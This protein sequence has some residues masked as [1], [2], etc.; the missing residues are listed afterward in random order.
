MTGWKK[1]IVEG[2]KRVISSSKLVIV[3]MEKI[4]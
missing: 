2:R 1:G 3:S 4:E